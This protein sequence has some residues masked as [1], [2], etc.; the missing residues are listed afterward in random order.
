MCLLAVFEVDPGPTARYPAQFDVVLAIE[1]ASARAWT[2]RT[3]LPAE[4]AAGETSSEKI[5]TTT[6]ANLATGARRGAKPVLELLGK[7]TVKRAP[8]GPGARRGFGASPPP[9]CLIA[10]R[11]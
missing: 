6:A 1:P 11:L 10:S 5:A 4:V 2:T 3:V 9:C 8:Q 7:P